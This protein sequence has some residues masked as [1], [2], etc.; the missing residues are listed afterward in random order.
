MDTYLQ[1][2][3]GT[4]IT[5]NGVKYVFT[6]D[7][8]VGSIFLE[9]DEHIIYCT[10]FWEDTKGIPVEVQNIEC[11]QLKFYVIPFPEPNGAIETKKFFEYFP[12]LLKEKLVIN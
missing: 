3:D 5:I 8:M 11:E 6:Y 7:I 12:T 9:S 10:P 4:E 1:K 2:L